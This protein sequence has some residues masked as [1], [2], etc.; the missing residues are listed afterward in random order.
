MKGQTTAPT[1]Q[2]KGALCPGNQ[3]STEVKWG[4][5]RYYLVPTILETSDCRIYQMDTWAFC[6][7]GCLPADVRKWKNFTV[8][9]CCLLPLWEAQTFK[10]QAFLLLLPDTFRTEVAHKWESQPSHRTNPVSSSMLQT[11]IK[12]YLGMLPLRKLTRSKAT[13]QSIAK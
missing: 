13:F 8:W 1:R 5:I 4:D 9:V 2:H 6:K 11:Q 7:V 10:H 12:S 3:K